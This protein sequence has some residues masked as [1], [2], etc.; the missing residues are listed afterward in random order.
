[1]RETLVERLRCPVDLELLQLD[2][3]NQD[4]D[5]HIMEGQLCCSVCQQKYKIKNGIPNLLLDNPVNINGENLD[6]L[7]S[8]TK[9]RFGF[10]W[11]YFSD[12]GW[13]T[14]YPDV[15]LA[16]EKFYGGL[17][18]HTQSA[19]WGK[20]L[21]QKEDLRKGL[22]VL[23]AGCGNGR[24]T[25]QAAQT[26]AEVIGIDL[27]KGVL[28]AFEHT[29]LLLNCHIVQGDIFRLPFAT[30]TFDRIFSIGVLQH[31]GDAAAA[32]D[33]LT[34]SLR[35]G[36]LIVA[37][38]YGRGMLTYEIIDALIRAVTTR[39]S[40]KMQI[41]FSRITAA[42]ARWLRSN[43]RW[44]LNLYYHLFRHINL[45]P[46][47]HHMFDCWSAPIS[48]HHTQDEVIGWFLKNKLRV[49]RTNPPLSDKAAER[50]R[51]R[52]HSSITVLGKLDMRG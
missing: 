33:S 30:H 41:N 10:E 40:I 19:F 2:I 6:Q 16:E 7:Q 13:L 21:F 49:I 1:M 20:S 27:G 36:G 22:L 51:H 17:I 5:G 12:W 52:T 14:D 4:K 29:R 24:F 38:V 42:I 48:T 43:T 25:N 34:R 45:L 9:E 46:T 26:G 11:R 35:K 39:L 28:S 31:T 37:H 50:I 47:E 23:D 18:Q 8:M 15:P 3:V 44:R 32:F